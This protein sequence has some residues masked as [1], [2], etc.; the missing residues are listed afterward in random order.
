M[1]LLR[2]IGV[3]CKMENF[4]SWQKLAKV[5]TS[6]QNM[7]KYGKSWQK[8]ALVGKHW[9]KVLSIK[10]PLQLAFRVYQCVYCGYIRR[11]RCQL[12]RL[13]PWSSR[14]RRQAST[15]VHSMASQHPY[16]IPSSSPR[17]GGCSTSPPPPP[18][19]LVRRPGPGRGGA[20]LLRQQLCNASCAE[21]NKCIAALFWS[22]RGLS[23]V[24]HIDQLHRV[25]ITDFLV[26]MLDESCIS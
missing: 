12:G 2:K 4:K 21:N 18:S 23:R 13:V 15:I 5:D 24:K 3:C 17:D 7:A 20:A 16:T 11:R 26:S 14:S 25:N 19:E 10:Q 1:V 22:Q 8:R 9:K 6:W